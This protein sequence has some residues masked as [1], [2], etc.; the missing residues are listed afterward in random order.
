MDVWSYGSLAHAF[1]GY[2]ILSRQPVTIRSNTHPSPRPIAYRD[3]QS[4]GECREEHGDGDRR[5]GSLRCHQ[6]IEEV[7]KAGE[8]SERRTWEGGAQEGGAQESAGSNARNLDPQYLSKVWDRPPELR[9]HRL[10]GTVLC[11]SLKLRYV[12]FDRTSIGPFRPSG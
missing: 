6:K 10:A 11:Y 8:D 4:R 2:M 9:N 7:E 12:S 3:H 1:D 5:R